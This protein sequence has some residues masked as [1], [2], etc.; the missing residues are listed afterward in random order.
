MYL[1]IFKM[2]SFD[3]MFELRYDSEIQIISN[4]YITLY[5]VTSLTLKKS[6]DVMLF[7]FQWHI[8][9]HLKELDLGPGSN[10]MSPLNLINLM[11]NNRYTTNRYNR[12]TTNILK[13][14]AK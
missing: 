11:W 12:Y 10:S 7:K 14:F 3:E 4:L 2:S 9:K 6:W 13:I 8:E 5:A 1:D